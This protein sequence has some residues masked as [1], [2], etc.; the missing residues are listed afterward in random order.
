MVGRTVKI[1]PDDIKIPLDKIVPV[2]QA[3]QMDSQPDSASS[4]HFEVLD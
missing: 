3:K 4:C 1:Y 2:V